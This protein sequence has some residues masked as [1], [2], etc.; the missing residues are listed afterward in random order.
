M[1]TTQ[2]KSTT[3]AFETAFERAGEAGEQLYAAARKAGHLYLDSYERA[4][5][6]AIDLELKLA[7]AS[8]QEW[9]KNVVQAQTDFARELTG[10]YTSTARSLLK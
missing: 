7:D 3:T 5:D 10:T 1:A 9:V 8:Q 4:V 2:T 6:R